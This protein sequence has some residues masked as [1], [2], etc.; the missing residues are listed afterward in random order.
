MEPQSYQL[1]L[2]GKRK[3]AGCRGDGKGCGGFLGWP[4]G[5]RGRGIKGPKTG[6]GIVSTGNGGSRDRER[7]GIKGRGPEGQGTKNPQSS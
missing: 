1:I 7:A 5:A 6:G 4:G 2:Y 3:E